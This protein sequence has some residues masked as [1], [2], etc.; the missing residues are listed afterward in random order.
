MLQLHVRAPAVPRG[1]GYPQ[2]TPPRLRCAPRHAQTPLPPL[3]LVIPTSHSP[4][5]P[6]SLVPNTFSLQKVHLLGD[7]SFNE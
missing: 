5:L 4:E 1:R 7:T 3:G 6:K 2:T